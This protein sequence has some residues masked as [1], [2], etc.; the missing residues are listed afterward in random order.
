MKKNSSRGFTLVELLV[1]IAIIGILIGLLL[2][3]VQAAR[4]AARR[5][6]CTNNLKQLGL[7]VQNFHDTYKRIP[8]QYC[9]PM[10][11]SYL[12]ASLKTGE[13]YNSTE[14]WQ[15]RCN[16]MPA[17]ACL[18]PFVEQ[19]ALF[20]KMT[21]AFESARS[22]NSVDA[23]FSPTGANEITCA[24]VDAFLCPSDGNA[25]TD[26]DTISKMS[27]VTCIGD[28]A[29]SVKSGRG[30]RNHR[31]LFCNGAIGGKVKMSTIEDGTSNT[32]AFSETCTCKLADTDA[33]IKSGVAYLTS[34]AKQPPSA[35]LALRGS[36][37]MLQ[38]TGK[39]EGYAIKGRRWL[40]ARIPHVSFTAVL[41]P[42]SPS[43]TQTVDGTSPNP[44]HYSFMTPSSNHSGGVNAVMCDGSVRFI[45]DT[46]DCGNQLGALYSDEGDYPNT[47][48]TLRGVWGALA[49]PQGGETVAAM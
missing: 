32:M 45:S 41:P 35:C 16:R 26:S 49:T 2:P 23:T 29:M 20:T 8:N 48:A 14:T 13:W 17:Q 6:Q 4:E 5:M 46:V 47:G 39:G 15:Y 12:P 36:G 43:C 3:A 27:Y 24:K 38:P 19:N 28:C 25:E 1:V 21:A 7:A 34:M 30:N 44:D 33:R 42:N 11:T 18:L 31:G 37:G 10:W 40:D 9:D 22:S